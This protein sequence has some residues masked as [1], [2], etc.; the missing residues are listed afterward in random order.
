[1][2][3]ACVTERGGQ[4]EAVRH[5]KATES[6]HTRLAAIQPSGLAHSIKLP[7]IDLTAPIGSYGYHS[8]PRSQRVGA[9]RCEATERPTRAAPDALAGT[10]R[11]CRS[12]SRTQPLI[13]WG[14][15]LAI[16]SSSAL[17]MSVP[18]VAAFRARKSCTQSRLRLPTLLVAG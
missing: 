2:G 16:S 4:G 12:L 14:P 7:R 10:S 17:A 3:A 18:Y 13:R 15:L 1:M 8:G 6:H 5:T 11:T 9:L